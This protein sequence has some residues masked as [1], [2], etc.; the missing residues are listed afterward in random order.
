MFPDFAHTE[1]IVQ[2][3]TLDAALVDASDVYAVPNPTD[4]LGAYVAFS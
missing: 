3:M 4:M 1:Y 2:G